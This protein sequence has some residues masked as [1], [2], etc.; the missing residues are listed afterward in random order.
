LPLYGILF[1]I[2]DIFRKY[3]HYLSEIRRVFT[4]YRKFCLFTAIFAQFRYKPC[5]WGV[6]RPGDQEPNGFDTSRVGGV[7]DDQEIRS[8]TSSI[9]AVCM[10]C[11]TTRRSGAERLRYKPCAW[12]VRRP[13]D[14]E[15]N[16]FDTSRVH[17]ESDDQE[18]RSRTASIQA[19]CMG[20]AT[21]RRSGAARFQHK[22]CG[23]SGTVV[24]RSGNYEP[25]GFD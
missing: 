14:Q 15:P 8:R 11:A 9:Q 19:V 7:C 5:A 13:G 17:G 6:R 25:H 21:T 20:C 1:E 23:W 18:I 2:L 24:R 4:H 16:V 12:G 22:P 10:G 3:V